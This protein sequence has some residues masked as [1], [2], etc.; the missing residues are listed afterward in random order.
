[1]TVGERIRF[2]RKQL[3]YSAEY[4]ASCLGCSPATIYRYENGYI[5]SKKVSHALSV[6]IISTIEEI[7]KQTG[8]IYPCDEVK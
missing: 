7:R 2:R 3:G 1:M 6:D 8:I 5:E 4:I